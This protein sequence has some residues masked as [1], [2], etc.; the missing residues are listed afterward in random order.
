M[1]RSSVLIDTNVWSEL[2]RPRPD[3][4]M[5]AWMREH[6]HEC[7]LSTIV[8]GEIRYGIALAQDERQ[9][10][11]QAFHDDLLIQVGERIADFDD[12]AA[13]VWGPLRARL[14]RDG[15]LIGER[16][17]LIAAHALSLDMPLVTRD[18]G[19]MERT[20]AT[21]INPWQGTSG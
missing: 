4:R 21:I 6:L 9:R 11:L 3:P 14:K 10:D 20:G 5:R 13:A 8:L 12:A 17:M 18:V 7:V 19:D 2:S 1:E 16:D 15:M